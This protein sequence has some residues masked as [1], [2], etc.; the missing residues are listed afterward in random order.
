MLSSTTNYLRFL[1]VATMTIVSSACNTVPEAYKEATLVDRFI[2]VTNLYDQTDEIPKMIRLSIERQ[3]VIVLT[4]AQKN[5]LDRSVELYFDPEIVLKEVQRSLRQAMGSD[6]LQ[7]VLKWYES[8]VGTKI[9]IAEDTLRKKTG[10]FID[11]RVDRE[12]KT[13]IEAL[14]E[15]IYVSDDVVRRLHLATGFVFDALEILNP[16]IAP[17][18]NE[19]LYETEGTVVSVFQRKVLNNALHAFLP[20][21]LRDLQQYKDFL[22]TPQAIIMM[23][24]LNSGFERGMEKSMVPWHKYLQGQAIAQQAFSIQSKPQP[25]IMSQTTYPF[26]SLGESITISQNKTLR[27]LEWNASELGQYFKN[28]TEVHLFTRDGQWTSNIALPNNPLFEGR[29]LRLTVQSSWPVNVHYNGSSSV[30][31]KGGH[32]HIKYVNGRWVQK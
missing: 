15:T 3:D 17:Q 25:K 20:L 8:Q 12:R 11:H 22:N 23:A 6:E 24:A 16:Y 26:F 32:F 18:K 7:V 27:G 2:K 19:F 5:F 29:S 1:V 28:Y 10:M 21:D 30:I 14:L 13:R 31:A 4:A 9:L